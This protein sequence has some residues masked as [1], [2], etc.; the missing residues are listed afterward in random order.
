MRE[1]RAHEGAG[2]PTV[3]AQRIG[4]DSEASN[5]AKAL[6]TQLFDSHYD[7]VWATLRKLGVA[8]EAADDAAQKVFLVAARKL[9]EIEPRRE[10][11]FLYGAALR[12]AADARYSSRRRSEIFAPL[13][14]TAAAVGIGP[15]ELL[16]QKRARQMLD[17]ILSS[18]SLEERS[19]FS[20]YEIDGM[21]MAEVAELHEIPLGTVASRLKRARETFERKV[22]VL[23]KRRSG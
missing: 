21:T 13:D 9:S 7:F 8:G 1:A 23:Q 6:F 22:A 19:V 10:R 15:D 14:N 16:D 5:D 3:G 4:V 17:D 18:M 12:I 20:L 2:E 11:A